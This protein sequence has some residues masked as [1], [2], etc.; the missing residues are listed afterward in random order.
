MYLPEPLSSLENPKRGFQG[1][2]WSSLLSKAQSYLSL[3]D[4]TESGPSKVV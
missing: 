3:K 4:P 2:R 1:Q